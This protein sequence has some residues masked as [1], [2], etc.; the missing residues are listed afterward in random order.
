V[1]VQ[2][3][4]AYVGLSAAKPATH[5]VHPIRHRVGGNGGTLDEQQAP[6]WHESLFRQAG[7]NGNGAL[8]GQEVRQAPNADKGNVGVL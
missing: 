1:R 7:A 4:D 3:Q 5:A 8:G 2:A 6:A